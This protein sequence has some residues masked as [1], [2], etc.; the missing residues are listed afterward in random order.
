M[1]KK[2]LLTPVLWGV[3]GG[4]IAATALGFATGFLITTSK[5]EALARDSASNAVVV[6]LAP[7]CLDNY[8][9]SSD[10]AAQLAALKKLDEWK[11]STFIEERGWANMPGS[12][13]VNSSVAAACAKLI[14]G[15]KT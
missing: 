3:A 14:L 11:Y 4:A 15:A 6:V 5:A 10:A 12:E 9:K 13:Q 8:R 2:S 7:I 1:S